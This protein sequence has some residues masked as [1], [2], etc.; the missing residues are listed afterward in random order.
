MKKSEGLKNNSGLNLHT[1]NLP[2]PLTFWASMITSDLKF[3][4]LRSS[5]LYFAN[6]VTIVSSNRRSIPLEISE[7]YAGCSSVFHPSVK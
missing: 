4:Y 2:V 3:T 5:I 7:F 1:I 6:K